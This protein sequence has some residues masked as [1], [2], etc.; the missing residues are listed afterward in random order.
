MKGVTLTWTVPLSTGGATITNYQIY[1]STTSGTETPLIL[2]GAV[3]TYTDTATTAGTRYYYRV[4]AVNVA[5][6]GAQSNEANARAR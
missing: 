2:V 4:A 3:T 5:G 6:P 1:R